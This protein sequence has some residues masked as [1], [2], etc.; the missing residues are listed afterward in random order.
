MMAQAHRAPAQLQAALMQVALTDPA[1]IKRM[2]A[3]GWKR[4]C[5][6]DL[7]SPTETLYS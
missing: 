6:G 4:T 1:K 5:N 3:S 2:I 7:Y